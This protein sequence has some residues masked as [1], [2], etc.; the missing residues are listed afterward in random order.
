MVSLGEAISLQGRNNIAEQIGKMTFQATEAQKTRA[1]KAGV[2]A[3]KSAKDQQK[4]ILDLFKQKGDYHRLILPKAQD[5]ATRTFQEMAKIKASGTPYATNQFAQLHLN[6]YKEFEQLKTESEQ[7][8]AFDEQIKTTDY[9]KKFFG[10][11][12]SRFLPAYQNAKSLEDLRKLREQDPAVGRTLNFVLDDR[13]VPSVVPRDAIPY[14]R[15]LKERV[16]G[17]Q[18][19]IVKTSTAALDKAYGAKAVT[20]TGVVPFTDAEV[21]EIQKANPELA[22][23]NILSVES[24]VDAYLAENPSLVEQI[25]DQAN[26]PY[27]PVPG[28]PLPDDAT[29]DKVREYLMKAAAPYA[30]TRQV[31]QVVYPPGSRGGAGAGNVVATDQE[32]LAEGS[33]RKFNY[34]GKESFYTSLKKVEFPGNEPAKS[35][36][37]DETVTMV[38]G[39]NGLDRALPDAKLASM[40]VLPYTVVNGIKRPVADGNTSVS[41]A[42]YHPFVLFQT[43]TNAVYADIDNY[44]PGSIAQMTKADLEMVIRQTRLLKK[45]AEE[46]STK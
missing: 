31:S 5:L 34:G 15:D 11:G 26:I 16:S 46:Q 18:P 19:L 30:K 40:E 10:Y 8:K 29:V 44:K 2:E 38:G 37:S 39:T 27:T 9:G 23:R 22:S 14:E 42:G 36:T 4:S 13:G 24:V 20:T 7:L 1:L 33:K 17:L 43:A 41:I 3:G 25:A 35:F 32:L 28:S 12:F 45:I 21:L 6:T